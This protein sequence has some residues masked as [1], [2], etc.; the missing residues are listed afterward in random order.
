MLSCLNLAPSE[1]LNPENVYVAGIIPGLKQPSSFQLSYLLMPLIKERKE[2][3]KGY[4]FHPPQQV[5]Q[6][7]LS[8]LP[9]SWPLWMWLPCASLL[10]LFLIQETTFVIFELFKKLKL[11]KLVLNFTTGTH[12][13]I[14]NQPL[15]NSLGQPQNNNKRFSLSMEC[16]IQFWKTFRIGMQPEWLVLT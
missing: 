15:P 9:S 10:D 8:M 1:R 2:L 14:I 7:P 11:K 4:H 6:D 5:L 12:T 13:K 3:L 16:N